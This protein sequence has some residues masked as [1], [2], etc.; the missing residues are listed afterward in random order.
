MPQYSLNSRLQVTGAT[1]LVLFFFNSWLSWVFDAGFSVVA[2]SM[3]FSLQRLLLL[4]SRG[5]RAPG[6]QWLQLPSSRAGSVVLVH[7]L[8]CSSACGVL[9]DQGVN[10]CLLHWQVNSL[11]RNHQGSLGLVS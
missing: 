10:P 8:S 2:A 6:L 5:C 4:W 7:G 11:P 3:G 1:E 9:P